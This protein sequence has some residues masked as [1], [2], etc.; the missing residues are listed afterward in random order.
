MFVTSEENKEKLIPTK[1]GKTNKIKQIK[2]N[3]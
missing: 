3:T 1:E 2:K